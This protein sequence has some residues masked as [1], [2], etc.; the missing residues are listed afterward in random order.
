MAMP[1]MCNPG[2]A[3]LARGGNL[4]MS[5]MVTGGTGFLG[6]HV[7]RHLSEGGKDFF[8]A[9]HDNTDL[10]DQA[11]VERLFAERQ[12]S[13]VIHL[14]AEVGG[15][16]ANQENPGRYWYSN[17][18]MA[19]NVVEQSRAHEVRKLTTVGSICA[20]PADAPIPFREE[21]LWAGYPEETNASYGVAKRA[22]LVGA[23]AYRQQYGTNII[24]LMPVNMYGP[25]D[26]FD[27]QT[28]HVI[29]AII[30]K[31]H[32]AA[33]R[34]D[35]DVV[36]WGDGSATREFLY[37]DDAA[38]GILLAAE[39]YNG[40]EPI[41]LGT[42][43]EVSIRELAQLIAELTGFTGRIVWDTSRPNGQPRRQL[44]VSRAREHFGFVASTPLEEG[45]RH[46]IDWYL[47]GRPGPDAPA[48]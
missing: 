44:D 12:P 37:A 14:A 48:P 31:M 22:L 23:Q 11:A 15:I 41:N 5:I 24:H 16:G 9:T 6:S 39:H 26:N 21:D 47:S 38:R 45:L 19:L 3:H 2:L 40:A 36:L 8:L 20:Y 27:L 43:Q 4:R 30:R 34:N 42:G 1:T 28:S 7:V 10:T 25:H 32:E 33:E 18:M 29:P 17:L 13:E 35:A 46:T